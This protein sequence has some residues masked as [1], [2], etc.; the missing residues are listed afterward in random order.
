MLRRNSL[1]KHVTVGKIEL[2]IEVLGRQGRRSKQLLDGLKEQRGYR[3][4]KEKTLDG[5]DCKTRFGRDYGMSE[6]I[7]KY[8]LKISLLLGKMT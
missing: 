4:L 1:L 3:R 2:G 7:D 5:T 6:S 8:R